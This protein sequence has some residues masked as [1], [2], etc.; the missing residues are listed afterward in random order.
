MSK[1]YIIKSRYYVPQWCRWLNGD[2]VGYLNPQSINGLNLFA[3][4]NNNPVMYSDGSG[5]MPEWLK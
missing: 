2:S 5:Y 3:Y 1:N 4:C